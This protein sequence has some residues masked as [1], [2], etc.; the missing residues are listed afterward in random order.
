MR[1]KLKVLVV[2][3]SLVFRQ[4]LVNTLNR[5]PGIE[6]VATAKDP[7]EARDAI[8]EHKPDVMTLDIQMPNMSGIEFLKKLLPQYKIPVV[9]VSTLS[10]KVFDAMDAG[11]VEFVGKPVNGNPAEIERF[12]KSELAAKIKVAAVAKVG[13]KIA[14]ARP[15]G[16]LGAS[17]GGRVVAI[18]ASTGGTEAI[19]DVIKGFDLDIPGV[20]VTQHMPAGFTAMYATRL[21]NTC[22]VHVKEAETGDLVA[23]GTVL[24][25]PGDKHMR[26][27]KVGDVFKV[28]CRAGERVSGHCPSIDVLFESVASSAGSKAI[29][30]LLTGM[31]ADGARG[32]LSMRKAGAETIGQDKSTSV[33]YGMPKVAYDLGAVK[34]QLRLGDISNKIYSLLR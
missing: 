3:D 13:R 12:V 20:V 8:L 6:V 16:H 31:G 23:R 32:L 15:G 18:G 24:I 22:K 9:M 30:V 5:D 33:V 34:Y 19:Y 11:A 26:L 27:V 28:E 17:S 29:G 10:D 1:K 21:E 2:D 4:F 7:Y 14:I 25:A